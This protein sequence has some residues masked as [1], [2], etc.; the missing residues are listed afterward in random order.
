MKLTRPITLALATAALGAGVAGGL[1]LGPADASPTDP[2]T[3]A[4]TTSAVAAAGRCGTGLTDLAEVVGIPADDLRAALRDGQTIAEVAEANGVERQAVVDAL[5][6]A[7]TAR[8]DAALEAGRIDQARADERA[9]ALPDRAAAIVDGE[10]ER[11]DRPRARR[12]ARAH[13]R[14]AE[15]IG[16]PAAD[17]RTALRDGQTIAE[18]AEANGVEPETVVDTLV[19]QA[20]ERITAVVNGDVRR[21]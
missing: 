12:A 2:A 7:G 17:L 13:G 8:I 20:G 16:I 1:A 14:V 21:C 9:A 11:P 5:V 18:V 3:P 19:G 10:L 15:A 4:G 6:A